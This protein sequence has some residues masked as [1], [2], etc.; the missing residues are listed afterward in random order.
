[1]LSIS[2]EKRQR[3]SITGIVRCNGSAPVDQRITIEDSCSPS[4]YVQAA[5]AVFPAIRG[6]PTTTGGEDAFSRRIATEI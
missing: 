6:E 2:W 5:K 4:A 3:P 1:M